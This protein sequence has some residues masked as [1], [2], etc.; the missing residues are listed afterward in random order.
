MC[1]TALR[2]YFHSLFACFGAGGGG[3]GGGG[4]GKGKGSLSF[5][6][7]SSSFLLKIQ[8]FFSTVVFVNRCYSYL[9]KNSDC[10]RKVMDEHL[11][12]L[13]SNIQS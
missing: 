4:V 9:T 13:I 11:R 2:K 3:G 10:E 5:S 8:I 1:L 7:L 12:S 6:P